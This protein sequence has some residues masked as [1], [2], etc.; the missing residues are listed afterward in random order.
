MAE[1]TKGYAKMRMRRVEKGIRVTVT[2][3]KELEQSFKTAC[4]SRP[5]T[6][7]ST[8]PSSGGWEFWPISMVSLRDD[9]LARAFFAVD[10]SKDDGFSK[11]LRIPRSK[12]QLTNF[13]SRLRD[14]LHAW[15]DDN[16]KEIFPA[17]LRRSMLHNT[18][19]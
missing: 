6:S 19:V 5:D 7:F 15:Y 12:E 11:V 4:A 16:V 9:E 14:F 18:K 1:M 10:T 8:G 3:D 2:M 13:A 17:Y